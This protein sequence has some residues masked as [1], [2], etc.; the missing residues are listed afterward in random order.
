[1]IKIFS[2]KKEKRSYKTLAVIGVILLIII[3]F[4]LLISALP[5]ASIKQK[6][7]VI[8]LPISGIL[9]VSGGE[10]NAQVTSAQELSDW[11]TQIKKEKDVKAVILEINSPG[12]G[13]VASMEISDKIHS[14]NLPT[15]AWIRDM[16]L[17]G[18]YWVASSSNYIISHQ[19]SL[20][21]NIGTSAAYLEF[22][23]LLESFNITYRNITS[24]KYKDI[25]S[26]LRELSSEEESLLHSK[27][28]KLTDIFITSVAQKRNLTN[29][30]IQ[31]IK[32]GEYF[33]GIEAIELNLIDELGSEQ[34][35]LNKVAQL[36]NTTQDKLQIIPIK[37]KKNL[38]ATIYGNEQA[39]KAFGEGFGK[40]FF[41]RLEIEAKGRQEIIA[42]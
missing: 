41:D 15:I 17:S 12:G 11:L 18:G 29:S 22:S 27:I 31:R 38:L 26:P 42:A 32:T 13:V 24:G 35:V 9:Q 25:G 28:D 20:V 40:A 3:L 21:G 10:N 14:L 16:S 39:A 7:K 4:S 6:S 23:G 30:Q 37:Q 5:K 8:L 19:A 34:Q 2:R 1:M 36:L 33:L